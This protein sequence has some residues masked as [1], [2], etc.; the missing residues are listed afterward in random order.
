MDIPQLTDKEK[1]ELGTTEIAKRIREQLKQEYPGCK[2]S[3]TSNH[4]IS[5]HLMAADF[6]VMRSMDGISDLALFNVTSRGTYSK[7]YIA[8]AQAKKYHQLNEYT[9]REAFDAE[10]W[11]NGVFLTETAHKVLQRV[12]NI[13]DAYNWD[14][15]D[16]QTDYYD[17]NFSLHLSIGRWDKPY[18][19]VCI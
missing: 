3:I 1:M 14:R 2:F 6:Q 12:V 5:I 10:K 15:S 17:V 18:T 16:S 19:G 7:E 13:A 9:L 8:E 4:G 11:N